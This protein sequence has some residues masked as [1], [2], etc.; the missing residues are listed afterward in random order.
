MDDINNVRRKKSSDIGAAFAEGS[1][2]RLYLENFVYVT[3]ARIWLLMFAYVNEL[4]V[5]SCCEFGFPPRKY[6]GLV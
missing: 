5:V 3:V 4:P 2:K 6:K 1:I